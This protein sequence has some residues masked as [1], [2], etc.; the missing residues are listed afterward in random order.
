MGYLLTWN[1]E[2]RTFTEANHRR[3]VRQ[4]R[5]NAT[6]RDWW[7]AGNRTNDLAAGERV[8]LLRQGT[9][10]G[11]FGSGHLE[12]GKIL[13]DNPDWPARIYVIFD[14]VLPIEHRLK[15]EDLMRA[16]PDGAWK[17]ARQSC[18]PLAPEDDKALEQL[19]ARHLRTVR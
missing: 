18:T 15:R 10:R 7:S 17:R 12:T 5:G 16:N 3:L 6:A 13:T 11:I 8:F 19:W 14:W 9:D 4:T 1:G 2:D